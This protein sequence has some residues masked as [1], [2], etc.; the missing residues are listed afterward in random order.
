MDSFMLASR[1]SKVVSRAWL[2]SVGDRGGDADER[3]YASRA[4][5]SKALAVPPA[6]LAVVVF[7]ASVTL[8]ATLLSHSGLQHALLCGLLQDWKATIVFTGLLCAVPSPRFQHLFTNLALMHL[9]VDF[10]LQMTGGVRMHVSSWLMVFEQM[11]SLRKWRA[12]LQNGAMVPTTAF[13]AL[14]ALIPLAVVVCSEPQWRPKVFWRGAACVLA[15]TLFALV[16]D[17]PC[18]RGD[19]CTPELELAQ[20]LNGLAVLLADVCTA[21]PHSTAGEPA[22]KNASRIFASR[23]WRAPTSGSAFHGAGTSRAA[24]S[25]PHA[26]R[27]VVLLTLESVSAV[28]MGLYNRGL[29]RETM[30][31]IASLPSR[32]PRIMSM[33]D[34]MYATEPNTLHSFYGSHCGLRPYVGVRRAEWDVRR[35]HN[36]CLP[37]LLRHNGIYS[38]LFSTSRL[39]LQ[40]DLN[41]DKV[42]FLQQLPAAQALQHHPCSTVV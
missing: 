22:A 19:L 32:R 37:T 1:V 6:G 24:G 31:F 18:C 16:N 12:L 35:Y 9:T 8:R 15:M 20:Q 7:F 34:R 27:N 39:S 4:P 33:V 25:A 10:G 11:A 3:G 23:L 2:L 17:P 26:S 40:R 21:R 13:Y 42:W 38:A 14:A 28:H 29:L 5:L 30:P 36:A 41:F